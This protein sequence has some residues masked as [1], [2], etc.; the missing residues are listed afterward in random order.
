MSFMSKVAKHRS[1]TTKI[2]QL[3]DKN[4]GQPVKELA[5]NLRVNRTFL[6]GYLNAIENEGYVRS[7]T[8]GPARIYFNNEVKNG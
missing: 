2:I 6:S 3:L 4:P 8:I 7:K 5:Q 1:L